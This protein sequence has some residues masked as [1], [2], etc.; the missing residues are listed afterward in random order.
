MGWVLVLGFLAGL[1][2]GVKYHKQ[3]MSLIA[4]AEARVATWK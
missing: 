3:I 1:A 2:L 4:A